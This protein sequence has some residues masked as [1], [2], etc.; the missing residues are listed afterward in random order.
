MEKNLVNELLTFKQYPCVSIFLPTSRP[1]HDTHKDRLMLKNLYKETEERLLK[2]LRRRDVKKLLD[3]LN[4]VT[5]TIDLR[6]NLDGIGIFVNNDYSKLV[7]FPFPVKERVI[8]DD[9]F[10]TR[11]IIR[12]VNRS[13]SYYTL[14]LSMK[15]ARLFECYRDQFLEI[16]TAGFPAENP[17]ETEREE[18]LS[19]EMKNNYS[20]NFFKQVDNNFLSFYNQNPKPLA[21]IGIIKNLGY[22]RKIA[23]KSNAIIAEING[24]HDE[25][26]P[27]G[28]AKIVWPA[29]REET[30]K[31]RRRMLDKMQDAIDNL[32]FASGLDE[33]WRLANEGRGATLF[34]EEGYYQPVKFN[35]EGTSFVPVEDYREPGTVDDLVDEIVEQ[36]ISTGG[37][38]VF[39]ENGTLSQYER[40]A[41]I[42]KY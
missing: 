4:K 31:N 36:V 40:I 24:N 33:V 32:K 1:P 3:R 28:I 7:R 25:T 13:T 35:E 6:E 18:P 11:D 38:V 17:A 19:D 26:P 42:L 15:Y 23:E 22:Y 29:V 16:D 27:E 10:A 8:I 34:V 5:E 2:E 14:S 30:L 37:E 9:T 12:A 21:L 20:I 39:P 41:M